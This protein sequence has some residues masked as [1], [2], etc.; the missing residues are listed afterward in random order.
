MLLRITWGGAFFLGTWRSLRSSCRSSSAA[1]RARVQ[2]GNVG[3]FGIT[4]SGLDHRRRRRPRHA[5]ADRGAAADAPVRRLH[6]LGGRDQLFIIL[7]GPSRRRQRHAGRGP[8]GE[9]RLAARDD[10]RAVPREHPRRHRAWQEG[11]GVRGERPSGARRDDDRHAAGP[12]LAARLRRRLHARRLPAQYSSRPGAGRG[13]G[14]R[15]DKQIDKAIY[16][17]SR[18]TSWCAASPAAGAALQ[19]GAVY[20]EANQPP[21]QAG[22]CDNCGSQLYQR[23][24]DKPEVGAHP[25]GGQPEEPGAVTRSLP[26]TGQTRSR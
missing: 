11:A 21:K 1:R 15:E 4:A 13:A 26:A 10:G 19:C 9:D 16:I 22:V 5:A 20:H 7:L 18:P 14:R 3:A 17:R 12:H 6:P 23:E 2:G 25:P 8:H 24:D